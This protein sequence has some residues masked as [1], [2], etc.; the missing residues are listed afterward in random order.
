[1]RVLRTP[2]KAS[3]ILCFGACNGN[4]SDPGDRS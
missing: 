4:S 2:I 1:M 3:L